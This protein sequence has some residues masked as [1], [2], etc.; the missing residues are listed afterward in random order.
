[1]VDAHYLVDTSV[2]GRAEQEPVGERLTALARQGRMWSCQ[3]VDLEVIYGSRA[4][5]VDEIASE[6]SA[7]PSAPIDSA[8]L[9][10][11][12]QVARLLAAS[13]DHRGAKP[14]DLVIA[15]AAEAA[16]LTILHYDSDYDRIGSVTMQ[17]TE[18]IA[19]PGTLDH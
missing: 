15:A 16:A 18:W 9:S 12:T 2:L 19:A 3:L 17:P 1:M 14:V 13:G 4:R 10:R 8:V 5:E 6:R 7:L 11:A